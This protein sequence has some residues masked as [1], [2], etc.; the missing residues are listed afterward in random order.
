MTT[1]PIPFHRHS[2]RMKEY[3]YSSPGA[4]FVTMVTNLR[5][6]LFGEVVDGEMRLNQYGQIVKQSWEWLATQY[7]YV[8]IDPYV[9][10]PNHFHGILQIF[11][12]DDHCKGGSR[13]APDP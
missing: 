10:M 3:D 9:V 8:D 7:P 6:N 13:P 2:I 12:P 4:Y 11:E 1:P 5:K